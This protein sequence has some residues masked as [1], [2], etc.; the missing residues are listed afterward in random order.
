MPRPD[1]REANQLRPVEITT[2]FQQYAE[3]SALIKSGNTW[4]L[5]A[6]SIEERVPPFL[7]GRGTGWVTAEYAMLPRSTHT[8]SGRHSGG[9]GK[10]IQRLIG[11]SL[12][13]AVNME[14]LGER[15][16]T[17]D[18][19]VLQ[20]DGGTRVASITGGYVALAL[21][22]DGLV[23]AGLVASVESVLR[24]PIAA[25]SV[26]IIDGEARLDLPYAEDSTAEVDMNVVM[27]ESG[28]LVEVQ[29]TGEQGTFSRAQL[30]SLLDLATEGVKRLCAAQRQALAA[31]QTLREQ[32]Q[33][34]SGA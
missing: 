32:A 8:R 14:A 11:R 7:A 27:T 13:A 28:H 2:G 33:P 30:D 17:I 9:R 1:G 10:E 23:R 34:E 26:G 18:C 29:G 20:A 19:D 3:G 24:E 12:R 31:A 6:A 5:C 15:A 4:V 25:I 16:I 21:A 22:V